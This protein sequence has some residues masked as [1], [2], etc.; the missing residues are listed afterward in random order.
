MQEN[1]ITQRQITILNTSF[2]STA[3]FRIQ[4]GLLAVFAMIL[5]SACARSIAFNSSTVVPAAEGKIMLKKDRNKN[6]AIKVEIKNLAAPEKLHPPKSTYILWMESADSGL[7]NLGQLKTSTGFFGGALKASLQTV[8]S[9]QPVR[10]FITAEDNA[11]P[12]YPTDQRVL[13][14]PVLTR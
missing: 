5:L 13:E 10:F 11:N 1:A 3:F 9:F 8:T 12:L 7:K 14:T 4:T 2:M 6:N